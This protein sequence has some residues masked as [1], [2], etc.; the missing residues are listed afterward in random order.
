MTAY[1][2]VCDIIQTVMNLPVGRVMLWDQKYQTPNDFDLFVVVRCLTA[3]TLGTSRQYI[4]DGAGGALEQFQI[5]RCDTLSIDIMSRGPD[6]RDRNHEVIASFASTYAEQQMAQYG[7]YIARGP[8]A[9]VA[10][11]SPDGA[12]IPY[13]FNVTVNLQYTLTKQNAV[14]YYGS[15]QIASVL[16]NN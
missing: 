7:F 1:E 9:M 8:I 11:D 14:G 13:R 16:L 3:K 2:R 4:D 5:T 10:I 15:S 6:A 12:A